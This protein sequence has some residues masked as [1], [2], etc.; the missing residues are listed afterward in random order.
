M[1]GFCNLVEN[2]VVISRTN[3]RV[4]V[5]FMQSDACKSCK[6]CETMGGGFKSIEAYDPLN[7]KVGDQVQVEVLAKHVVS[8]SFLVFIVPLIFLI[9]GYYAGIMLFA[10]HSEGAG[11]LGALV[12][13]VLSFFLVRAIDRAVGHDSKMQ[14][15]VTHVINK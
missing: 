11:I 13:L 9:A 1:K 3:D 10:N 5:Q 7:V 4:F 6:L 14:A 2:G 8:S 15:R 12:A